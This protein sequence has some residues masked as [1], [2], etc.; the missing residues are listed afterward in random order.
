M[1]LPLVGMVAPSC[2]RS[3]VSPEGDE[4]EVDNVIFERE[5]S[6]ASLRIPKGDRIRMIRVSVK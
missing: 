1:I 4:L 5:S 6:K 2:S 3:L